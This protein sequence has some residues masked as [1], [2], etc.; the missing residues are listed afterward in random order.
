M[1]D[2]RFIYS[3]SP[4][5]P[6]CHQCICAHYPL[7][8]TLWHPSS[9]T[10]TLSGDQAYGAGCQLSVPATRTLGSC[11][12][13][14]VVVTLIIKIF[15]FHGVFTHVSVRK[16]GGQNRQPELVTALPQTMQIIN[17]LTLNLLM[18]EMEE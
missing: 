8:S 16:H 9:L 18:C 6:F 4:S 5:S 11:Y 13:V 10:S 15:H 1:P 14:L 3:A 2:L 7:L 12:S 17:F